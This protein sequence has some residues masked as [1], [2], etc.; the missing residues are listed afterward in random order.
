[1]RER[2]KKSNEKNYV[3]CMLAMICGWFW[4]LFIIL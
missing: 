4:V 3:E 1:M 2:E